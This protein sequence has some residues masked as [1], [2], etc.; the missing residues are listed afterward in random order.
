M[1]T[2][3]N[4]VRGVHTSPVSPNADHEA[5]MY[6]KTDH[7]GISTRRWLGVAAIITAAVSLAGYMVAHA[8]MH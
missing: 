4:V 2:P 6:A 5:D 8:I 1:E 3:L 7:R